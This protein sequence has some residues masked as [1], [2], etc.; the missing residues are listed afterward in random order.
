MQFHSFQIQKL[1]K[2]CKVDTDDKALQRPPNTS[3]SN[4]M[5]IAWRYNSLP[6][7]DSD[8]E[9]TTYFDSSKRI[10]SDMLAKSDI[11]LF[12]DTN[13]TF[14]N[15]TESTFRNPVYN[16][17]LAKL[18]SKLSASKF[19]TNVISTQSEHEKNLLRISVSSMG[20]PLWYDDDFH[21]DVCLFLL[22]LKALIRTSFA[23]GCI[24]VP[25]YL[26]QYLVSNYFSIS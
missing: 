1:P 24:T 4:D 11:E 26:F 22:F 16:Q 10:D 15:S 18:K 21:E 19:S 17:I 6:L 8:Q 2:V 25:A 13:E 9:S 14:N 20:S 5:R 7:I 12:K 23:V 3:Q